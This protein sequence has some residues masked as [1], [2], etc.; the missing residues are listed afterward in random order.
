MTRCLSCPTQFCNVVFVSMTTC[1]M[2]L[3][4]LAP[5]YWFAYFLRNGSQ[6]WRSLSGVLLCVTG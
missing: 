5:N 1:I 2:C 6:G 3:Q 4:V